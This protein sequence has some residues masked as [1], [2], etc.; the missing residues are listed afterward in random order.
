VCAYTGWCIFIF[1]IELRAIVLKH[2]RRCGSSYRK[3]NWRNSGVAS[4]ILIT[5][6]ERRRC[7]HVQTVLGLFFR[8]CHLRALNFVFWCRW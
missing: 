3:S 7:A 8:V 6:S 4:R 1:G 5:N 2:A